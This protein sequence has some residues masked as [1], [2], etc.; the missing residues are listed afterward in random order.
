MQ[1]HQIARVGTVGDVVIAKS[2][3]VWI[4]VALLLV[5]GRLDRDLLYLVAKRKNDGCVDC[6]LTT[7]SFFFIESGDK[8]HAT[9]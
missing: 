5:A 9:V 4:A 7:R 6:L 1:R 8:R 2:I 3:A